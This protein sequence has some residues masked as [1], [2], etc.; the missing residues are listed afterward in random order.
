MQIKDLQHKNRLIVGLG[1]TGLSVARFLSAQNLPFKVMDSRYT[2]LGMELKGKQELEAISAD[3][4][5]VWDS[6][7]IKTFDE[8]VVSPG[9]STAIKEIA[10]AEELG[11]SIVGDIELFA[12][13]AEVPVIAITGSNGKSTVTDL[14]GVLIN[15]AGKKALTGGNI[16]LPALDL[17]TM[18]A[19]CVVLEL[20]SFQ[21]ETTNSL[22]PVAATILNLSEDHLDRYDSYQDYI[23]AKQRIYHG[24]QHIVVNADDKE[25]WVFAE[26]VTTFGKATADWQLYPEQGV[27]SYRDE[28]IISISDL[29]LQGMH[30]A[31]NV[32]AALALM[33]AAKIEI[34]SSVIEAAKTYSGLSHRC[35]LVAV[36]QGVTYINDSKATNVGATVAAI[37]SFSQEF[38]TN[39]ILISGGDSKEAD[40]EPLKE[41]VNNKVKHNIIFGQDKEKIYQLVEQ[42]DK[43][44]IVNDLAQAVTEASNK[45]QQGDLVL[46][47][48]ACASLDMF[49]NYMQRGEQFARLVEAL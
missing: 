24:A 31:L 34:N 19:D 49:S 10:D 3:S 22:K 20:S 6:E 38:A 15:A 28:T 4:L 30:N 41:V 1:M 44:I 8:L 32:A 14:L 39:I 35:Q 40:L 18:D 16:G 21:L 37:E 36:K 48:P 42:K 5:L 9:I 29:T 17:V 13:V 43:A 45:A 26:K 46:L 12:Q 7:R 11:V 27:I 33:S 2:Q 23:Y 47:S 25:T